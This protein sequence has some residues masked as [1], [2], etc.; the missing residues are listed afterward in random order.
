MTG[1]I[2]VIPG[3]AGTPNAQGVYDAKIEVRD[4]ANPGGY[5]P[6]TNNKG[7]STMFPDHWTG[8]RIKVEVDAACKNRQSFKNTANGATMW[9]GTTPSG[10]LVEGYTTPNVTVYP[11]MK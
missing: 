1:D 11:K 7:V 8:D 10:V 3:T 6:K 5:L 9:R 2:R 4:P